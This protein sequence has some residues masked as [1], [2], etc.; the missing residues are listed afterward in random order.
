MTDSSASWI[1][2][3]DRLP[4]TL[5]RILARFASLSATLVFRSSRWATHGPP[6]TI[7]CHPHRSDNSNEFVVVHNGIITNYKELKTLLESK[8]YPFESQTDTECV[9]KLAK[10]IWD[11]QKGTGKQLSFTSLVKAVIKELVCLR[12]CHISWFIALALT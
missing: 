1:L 12:K 5:F 10:Y 11:Q 9:A 2:S 7:N 3:S 4:L 8:G 6:S